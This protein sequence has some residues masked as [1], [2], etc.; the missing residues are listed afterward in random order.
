MTFTCCRPTEIHTCIVVRSS[1]AG[2]STQHWN[3]AYVIRQWALDILL[4]TMKDAA[5]AISSNGSARTSMPRYYALYWRK[6]A[7]ELLTDCK[8][9]SR[10]T[11]APA[12]MCVGGWSNHP[13][14]RTMQV[15]TQRIEGKRNVKQ[16]VAQNLNPAPYVTEASPFA[17]TR[18][19]T[20][21]PL[22]KLLDVCNLAKDQPRIQGFLKTIGSA[23]WNLIDWDA[24]S[25]P[26]ALSANSLV[27]LPEDA[28]APTATASTTFQTPLADT[29]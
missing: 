23:K 8:R 12:P 17:L 18:T 7:P 15:T 19:P 11:E 2:F 29:V 22:W 4:R 27:A 25:A 1:I 14:A 10:V 3:C 13:T 28:L 16:L 21:I 20:K 9:A 5:H 6:D 24:V 26:E